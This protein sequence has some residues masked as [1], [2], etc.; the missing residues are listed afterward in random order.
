VENSGNSI[1][2]HGPIYYVLQKQNTERA[3]GWTSWYE[4]TCFITVHTNLKLLNKIR[5]LCNE[6][7]HD[8]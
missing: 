6:E 2:F 8:L 3:L 7:L 5:T 4:I 1:N